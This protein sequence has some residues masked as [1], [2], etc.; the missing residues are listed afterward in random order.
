MHASLS[1]SLF[2]GFKPF[3]HLDEHFCEHCSLHNEVSEAQLVET[4]SRTRRSPSGFAIS[5]HMLESAHFPPTAGQPRTS[6]TPAVLS[7]LKMELSGGRC[8]GRRGLRLVWPHSSQYV[9]SHVGRSKTHQDLTAASPDKLRKTDQH[10]PLGSWKS[11]EARSARPELTFPLPNLII[12]TS[13]QS[14]TL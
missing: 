7:Q 8:L 11:M 9:H 5:L 2:L 6:P 10:P 4:Q 1:I 3:K 14:P 12:S 13:L